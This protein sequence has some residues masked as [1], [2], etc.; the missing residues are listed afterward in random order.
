M[1]NDTFLKTINKCD[2]NI[3]AD[4]V[5]IFFSSAENQTFFKNI[6]RKDVAKIFKKLFFFNEKMLKI[7]KKN[8]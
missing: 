2:I 1:E 3:I 6:F 7:G 5:D 4:I 8:F